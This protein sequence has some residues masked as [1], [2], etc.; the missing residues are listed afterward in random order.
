MTTTPAWD[1]DREGNAMTTFGHFAALVNRADP[2]DLDPEHVSVGR[3]WVWMIGDTDDPDR[4]ILDGCDTWN[5]VTRAQGVTDATRALLD[6]AAEDVTPD[7]LALTC[8]E[9]GAEP[10]EGCRPSCTGLA[11][12]TA[13]G[14]DAGVSEGPATLIAGP[15][16]ATLTTHP[17]D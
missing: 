7:P 14:E 15:V 6:L 12:V 3:E 13:A 11:S 10:G 4:G 8:D 2:G 1:F 9:C 16:P 17:K 5:P